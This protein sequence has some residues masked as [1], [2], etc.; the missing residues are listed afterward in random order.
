MRGLQGKQLPQ[1]LAA[2]SERVNLF[3]MYQTDMAR[4]LDLHA[5]TDFMDDDYDVDLRIIITVL[6]SV[7]ALIQLRTHAVCMYISLAVILCTTY[8]NDQ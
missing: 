4:S 1:H 3:N 6:S 7:V 5:N 8:F 2:L